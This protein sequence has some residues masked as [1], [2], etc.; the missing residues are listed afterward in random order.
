MPKHHETKP[1]HSSYIKLSICIKNT[2][3]HTSTKPSVLLPMWKLWSYF[4]VIF[5]FKKIKKLLLLL[6]WLW[7]VLNDE[8]TSISFIGWIQSVEIE[9]HAETLESTPEYIR[10]NLG[11]QESRLLDYRPPKV[12]NFIWTFGQLWRPS[13]GPIFFQTFRFQ[14][15]RFEKS[16]CRECPPV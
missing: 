12:Q 1:L 10:E 6:F 4:G 13:W 3:S 9:A 8:K 15:T 11:P 7:Q 5:K 14:D 16:Q 2:T